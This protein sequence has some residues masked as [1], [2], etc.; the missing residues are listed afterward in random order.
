[1]KVLLVEPPIS[2]FDVPTG[3]FALPTVYHL[4]RLAGAL[5]GSHDVEILDMRIDDS[6]DDLKDD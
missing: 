4:E 5:V 1:M 3:L 2:P 6:M